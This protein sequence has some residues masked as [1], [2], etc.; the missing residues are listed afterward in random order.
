MTMGDRVA[1]IN[2]G[3]LIQVDNP[4]T[5]YNKPKDTFVANKNRLELDFIGKQESIN[6]DFAYICG[7]IR[8]SNLQ[9]GKYNT[10]SKCT[11][12]KDYYDDES[13]REIRRRYSEDFEAFNY[14]G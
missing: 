14:K 3:K 13:Q 2:N 7:L 5:L 8:L 9:L 4:S 1:I 12:F 11:D 6:K 10:S